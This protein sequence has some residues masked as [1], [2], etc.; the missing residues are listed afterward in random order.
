MHRHFTVKGYNEKLNVLQKSFGK[1]LLCKIKEKE[2]LTF[3]D[4]QIDKNSIISANRYLTILKFVFKHGLEL[5]AIIN[6]PIENIK[7]LNEKEHERK[8]FLLPNELNMLIEASRKTRAKY[9]LPTI[10]LLG[11]EHGA[12]KQEILALTWL[13]IG[14]GRWTPGVG[15]PDR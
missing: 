3:R 8:R 10:I 15:Q 5:K 11:A 2:V 12:S 6:N 1:T 7:L 14:F 4:T 13:K 9:Y